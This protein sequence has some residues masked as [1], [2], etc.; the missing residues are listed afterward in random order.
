MINL[1][2][3]YVG[4][5]VS[6]GYL[7]IYIYPTEK[8]FK[9]KNDTEGIKQL[10]KTLSQYCIEQVVCESSGGYEHNM[11]KTLAKCGYK[12]WLVDPKRIKGFIISEGIKVK[13]D[14]IDAKMIALFASQKKCAY[15]KPIKFEA[16]S[17]LQILVKRRRELVAIAADEKKRLQ[18]CDDLFYQK[19]IKTIVIILKKEIDKLEKKIDSLTDDNDDLRRKKAIIKSVPGIGSITANALLAD[20]HELGTITGKEVSA[21]IGVA[22]YTRQSGTYIGKSYI[23]GGRSYPRHA[24]YMAALSTLNRPK[25]FGIFYKKLIDIGK[26]PKVAIVA[27]MRKMIVC[28]NALLKKNELWNQTMA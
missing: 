5:D 23:S 19:S 8:A 6:K 11:L 15:E 12:T 2:K 16:S 3:V 7:D 14:S 27:V 22:P 17:E 21:L 24:L 26:A 28:I 9:V 18:Q 20:V 1:P 25:G 4:V 13:T 10:K